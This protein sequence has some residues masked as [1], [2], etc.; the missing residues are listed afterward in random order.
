MPCFFVGKDD[1]CS[2]FLCVCFIVTLSQ[3][4][5]LMYSFMDF[6]RCIGVKEM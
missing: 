4:G 5:F 6:N 3:V 2:F 1:L